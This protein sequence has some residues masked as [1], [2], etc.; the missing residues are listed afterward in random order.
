MSRSNPAEHQRAIHPCSRWFEYDGATGSV[1]YWDKDKKD[2]ENPK[3]QYVDIGSKFN[4]IVLDRLAVVKGWHEPSESGIQSNEVRDTKAERLVVKAFKGGV[5]AEGFYAEIR[6]RVKAVG[7]KFYMSLYVAY[8]RDKEAGLQL[9]NL[10]LHGAGLNAWV[11]F[12]KKN[13]EEI[14]TKSVKLDGFTK[15]KKG[16]IEFTIPKFAVVDIKPET[17]AEAKKV[18]E[19]LQTYLKEYFKRS[20]T[21]QVAAPAGDPGD[22]QA[23]AEAAAQAAKANEEPAGQPDEDSVPF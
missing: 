22:E 17:D 14:W 13:R 6:D 7:G 1:C 4:F 9:G 23:E 21:E 10:C 20:R 19:T 12:E 11:E 2:A 15:G 8:K 18:D 5:L 16:A 3:G